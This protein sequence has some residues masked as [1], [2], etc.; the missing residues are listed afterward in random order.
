MLKAPFPWFGGKSRV[1]HLVWDRFGNVPNYVEPFFGSGAVLLNRP[2]EPGIET[3]N[4]LDGFVSNAWRA[5]AADPD[6]VAIAADWPISENDLHARHIWLRSQRATLSARLEAD[7]DYF[8]AKIAGWWLWGMASWIGSGFCGD[9]GT[10]PWVVEDGMLVDRNAGRG[11]ARKLPHLGTAGQGIADYMHQLAARLRRVRVCCGDWSRVVGPSVTWKHGITGIL[12]DP[13]YADTAERTAD[14]YA[15]DCD[16]VAHAVRGWAIE[17]GDN[18]QLRIALCGYEGEHAM[19]TNWECVAWKT[20]GGY[21]SQG[22][23]KGREN[24]GKERIRFS[25]HCLRQ[26]LF[27]QTNEAG[28]VSEKS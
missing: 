5:I 23:G 21:G 7:P 2:H 27:A 18:P 17:N 24:A 16:Q 13:P 15:A 14:L 22:N 8:D 9:S 1:A 6:G 10:G 4:D 28:F 3:V 11:I 26:G 25:P 20:K 12:L 19:P